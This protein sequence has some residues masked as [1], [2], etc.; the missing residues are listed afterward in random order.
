MPTRFLLVD[1]HALI[2]EGLALA[3]ARITEQVEV[4][5]AGSCE[6]ALARIRAAGEASLELD[7]VVLDLQLPGLSRLDA[8]DAIRAAAP[9]TPVVVLSGETSTELVHAV[10]RA[11]ARGYIPKATPTDQLI[12][13]LRL[14]FAG[15][16]YVPP[17]VLDPP[18]PPDDPRAAHAPV[19]EAALT[20]RQR[21]VLAEL[22]RGAG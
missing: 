13:A 15:G 21:R 14:V 5:E 11:G 4:I 8:L 1:D 16:I 20:P 12:V 7:L 2:R 10:L 19:D 22:A 3:L 17:M 18:A 9:S 6:D